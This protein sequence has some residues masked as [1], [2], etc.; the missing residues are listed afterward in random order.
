MSVVELD[1]TVTDRQGSPI[2]GLEREDFKLTLDGRNIESD[3]FAEVPGA[4][5]QPLSI[6]LLVDSR[7]LRE[8]SRE[9]AFE[10][11]LPEIGALLAPEGARARVVHYDG[12]IELVQDWTPDPAAIEA[13]FA[14]VASRPATGSS[15][16]ARETL[17]Q[18]ALQEMLANMR[19]SSS[20]RIVAMASID[21]VMGEM[22][23]Y[24]A[25][26]LRETEQIL[27]GLQSVVRSLA[28]T[29]GRKAV[30]Y[31]TGGWAVRPGG[32]AM[33]R[34][35]SA[36]S[37]TSARDNDPAAARV[38]QSDTPGT[39]LLGDGGIMSRDVSQEILR[40]RQ[41]VENQDLSVELDLLIAAAN[42]YRIR[43]FP[44][45][46]PPG[47]AAAADARARGRGAIEVSDMREGLLRLAEETGGLSFISETSIVGALTEIARDSGHHY[48][49]ALD[50]R[51]EATAPYRELGLKVR[52]R[53]AVVRFPRLH[54]PRSLEGR[55]VDLAL[56]GLDATATANPHRLELASLGQSPGSD[57]R[58]QV[59][60]ALMFPIERLGLAAASGLHQASSQVAVAVLDARGRLQDQ[61]HLQVPL[62]IP[63][64]DLD[65]ARASFYR[66][67]IE[68]RLSP[69]THRVGVAMWDSIA[70]AASLVVGR[71]EVGG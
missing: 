59:Q 53:G 45:M 11:L 41:A 48:S 23:T 9:V 32:S 29:P 16:D 68:L 10:Q 52:Q 31:L 40:G 20:E 51:G 56:A 7:T 8:A 71:I 4:G 57:G 22:R 62:Q 19:G 55:L 2:T 14:Q 35:Q 63:D 21:S 49:L 69:G 33:N 34:I 67:A 6:L 39:T 50:A 26:G 42:A 58:Q 43:F 25:E 54:A 5:G 61:Q 37:G 24:A 70:Q 1:V 3:Y 28:L 44:L 66:A 36:M 64:A 15:V 46:P 30:V 17:A 65:K 47:D 60:L 27:L 18:Q 38:S 13:A 12:R